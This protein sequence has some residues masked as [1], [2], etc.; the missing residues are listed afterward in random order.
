MIVDITIELGVAKCLVI[1]GI[2][3]AYLPSA[4]ADI[5]RPES[6]DNNS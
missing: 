5:G 1:L 3:Q 2:P 4:P 6:I